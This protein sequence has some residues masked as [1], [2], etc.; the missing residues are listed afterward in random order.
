M[1]GLASHF[2]NSQSDLGDL[3]DGTSCCLGYAKH[4]GHDKDMSFH[5][6]SSIG[7]HRGTQDCEL[8]KHPHVLHPNLLH[9]SSDL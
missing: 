5:R 2:F 9:A 1:F 6:I 8:N 4:S 7:A 3:D